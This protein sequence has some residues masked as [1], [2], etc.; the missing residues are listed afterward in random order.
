[1]IYRRLVEEKKEIMKSLE[2]ENPTI[3]TT[4]TSNAL[5]DRINPPDGFER[6]KAKAGSFAEYL[7]N[8][9]L[10]PGKPPVLLYNGIKKS[11]QQAHFAIVDID[12]G[13]KDLQQCADAVIR[14]R[15]EYL[16]QAQRFKDIHFNFTSGDRAD[17]IDWTKGLRPVV[18]GNN[19]TWK[20]KAGPDSTYKSFRQYLETVF[21]YAGSASLASELSPVEVAVMRIG[22]VFIHGGFPGH[23]ILIA[24]MAEDKHGDKVF[25]IAQSYMPA[26][27]I[28]ILRNPTDAGISPWYRLDFGNKLAT[29][30][31]E[32]YRNELYRFQ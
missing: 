17:F 2:K 8:L 31:W 20:K 22:D 18:K 25:L 27:D 11:N 9:K 3:D 21:M 16:Y 26:Q 14:L 15:A 30:E 1:M 24:D 4:P 29:P 23:A 7:R 19:V 6:I 28:H 10:K 13:K 5:K 32:F 12:V